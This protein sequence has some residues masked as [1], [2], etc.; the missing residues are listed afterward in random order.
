[1]LGPRT[2]PPKLARTLSKA[3]HGPFISWGGYWVYFFVKLE[4]FCLLA[5]K[6]LTE[7]GTRQL[8]FRSHVSVL[9]K[10]SRVVV[11]G[12]VESKFP[13]VRNQSRD[14]SSVDTLTLTQHIQLRHEM[15]SSMRVTIS[16]HTLNLSKTRLMWT[17]TPSQ[18]QI[19]AQLKLKWSNWT[20]NTLETFSPD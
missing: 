8:W 13:Q 12:A 10:V 2:S 18:A 1:M 4:S 14:R 15:M 20:Q 6:G 9:T 7:E 17:K 3:H 16:Q 5:Q 11:G 19:S